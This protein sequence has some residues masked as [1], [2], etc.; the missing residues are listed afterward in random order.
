ML[1][2]CAADLVESPLEAKELAGECA[3]PG[4]CVD[5][6]EQALVSAAGQCGTPSVDA[7]TRAAASRAA[8]A[9]AARGTGGG[10]AFRAAGDPVSV[11]VY[12][13]VIQG[14]GGTGTVT[15]AT[16]DNQITVLNNSFGTATGGSNTPFSFVRAGVD[17]TT[18]QAWFTMAID[19]AEERAAKAALRRGGP[20]DL[21][22]YI[23]QMPG[24]GGWARWPWDYTQNPS[25]DGV[26][27]HVNTV[28]GDTLVHEVGHWLGL[29]HTFLDGCNDGDEVTDT[30]AEASPAS[31]CPTGRNTCPAAGND[32]ITNF[33]DYSSDAC[34]FQFT[35]GQSA[36]MDSF[37]TA[38]RYVNESQV[39]LNSWGPD[40]LDMFMRGTDGSVHHR[41]WAGSP[42]SWSNWYSIG[43]DVSGAPAVVSWG[44]QRLDLF[45][46]GQLDRGYWH[47]AW[48]PNSWAP[49]TTGWQDLG[50]A[51]A[52]GS[53]V[54]VSWASG[55][56]DIFGRGTD[57]QYYHKA[58]DNGWHPSQLTWENLGG[59]FASSP[60]AVSWGPNRLDV[61]GEGTDR[62]YYHKAWGGSAW[63]SWTSIGGSFRGPP[64]AVSW[65]AERLD[66]FGHGSDGAYYHK[67]WAN[68]CA[69]LGSCG[70]WFPSQTTWENLGGDFMSPPKA[71]SWGPDRLDVVGHGS[72]GRYYH[73][74]WAANAWGPSQ[75]GWNNLD[76]NFASAPSIESWGVN[77]LDIVG[78]GNDA[79][80]F[81]KAW[82]GTAWSPGASWNNLGGAP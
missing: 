34:R 28:P 12:F 2:G 3:D 43:G 11:R 57:G 80:A 75:L 16:L 71:V 25:D 5:E 1:T 64:V 62:Q 9:A 78:R 67:A 27:L 26:V 73:K 19:S 40:R 74:A 24:F 32:P 59:S 46:Q 45:A 14:T 70:A 52:W 76:G 20:M 38:F 61:F 44:S 54:A 6:S 31:G 13:H 22:I 4:K 29:F 51:F 10:T 7:A 49:S 66:V 58:Y 23:A 55:R 56:L 35:A 82:T 50:G 53:P 33:M 39:S 68:P 17:R 18:N 47:K 41:A 36:R 69:P 48:A 77:R 65:S 79:G 30:P 15:D 81:H 8:A 37:W 60:A 72:D 42:G 63:S 21:N